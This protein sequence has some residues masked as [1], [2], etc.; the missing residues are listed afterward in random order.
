MASGVEWDLV[1]EELEKENAKLKEEVFS[2]LKAITAIVGE[3]K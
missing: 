1:V 3:T 2:L